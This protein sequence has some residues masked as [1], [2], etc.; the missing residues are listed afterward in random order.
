MRACYRL[1]HE[2][3]WNSTLPQKRC[4]AKGKNK[5]K[6]NTYNHKPLYAEVYATRVVLW[7][8]YYREYVNNANLQK[9]YK[10]VVKSEVTQQDVLP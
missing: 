7:L 6:L 2:R 4:N 3:L 10:Y 1:L 5:F 9:S 8:N